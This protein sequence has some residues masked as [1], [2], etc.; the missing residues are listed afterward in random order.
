MEL[1]HA[2]D[3]ANLAFLPRES[4]V[5]GCDDRV[6]PGGHHRGHV[7]G[8]AYERAPALDALGAI[9]AARAAIEGSD[10]D[11]RGHLT[12]GQGIASSGNRAIRVVVRNRTD[13]SARCAV[14][15]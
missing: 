3:E 7:E 1:S 12:P 13:S 14:V 4:L 15:R 5:E 8:L 6:V 10:A 11:Q 2:G 9:L